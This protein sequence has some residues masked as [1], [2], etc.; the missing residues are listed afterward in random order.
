LLEDL[1]KTIVNI[2]FRH[3]L[4]TKYNIVIKKRQNTIFAAILDELDRLYNKLYMNG[5]IEEFEA[6][7]LEKILYQKIIDETLVLLIIV[8]NLSF[9]FA[10]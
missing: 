1:Y 4:F 10:K 2:N 9:L 6:K 8:R 3:H 7:I 5:Q